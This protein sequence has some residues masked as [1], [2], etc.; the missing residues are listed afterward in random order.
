[1]Q[2]SDGKYDKIGLHHDELSK[3]CLRDSDSRR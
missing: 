1:M 2:K 3:T